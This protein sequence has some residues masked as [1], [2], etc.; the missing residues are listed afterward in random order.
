MAQS[1]FLETLEKKL[2]TLEKDLSHLSAEEQYERIMAR[3]ATRPNSVISPEDLLKQLKRSKDTGKPL[4]IKFGIDP[5]GP[6]IHIGHAISMINLSMFLRMGHEL[7]IVVGDFTAKIGDPSGRS[8]ERP[9]LTDEDIQKNMESYERQASRLIDFK[10]ERVTKHFNSEWMSKLTFAEWLELL[11]GISLS[12][13]IQRD[14]FRKRLDKGLGVSLAEMEYGLFMGYDSIA[15]KSDMEIGGIDQYLNF[16]CCRNM[17]NQAR[18]K[19]EVILTYDLLPGMSGEKDEDGRLVK[20]SKSKGNYIPIEADPKDMYGKVMSIPDEVMWVW[21]REITQISEDE[22]SKLKVLVESQ[23][24]HP[25]D[26]K[27]LLARVVVATFNHYDTKVV[28]E[29]ERDFDSKFGKSSSLVPDN[30]V[31]VSFEPNEKIIDTL[32]RVL[33]ESKGHVR[34]LVK[35]SGIRILKAGKYLPM[36]EEELERDTSFFKGSF[37]KVGKIHFYEF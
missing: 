26:A 8:N 15:L 23:E 9:P 34:R 35:Q 2:L 37:I 11:K 21:Y 24:L 29:A 4:K 33:K 31:K 14:D 27:K 3:V 36:T 18:L 28:E 1:N 12:S 13:M 19:P 17:M 16:H 5:T 32:A 30:V 10:H 6:E 22:R 7:Q 25:K 20:M